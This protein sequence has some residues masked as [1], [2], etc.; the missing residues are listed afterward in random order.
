MRTTVDL[1]DDIYRAI[2][3]MAAER[4]KTVRELVLEGLEMVRA[5]RSG[6]ESESSAESSQAGPLGADRETNE[7]LIGFP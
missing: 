3:V 2:K 4:G 7:D 6:S 1:P 5:K